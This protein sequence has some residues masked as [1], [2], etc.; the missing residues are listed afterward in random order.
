MLSDKIRIRVTPFI[1][2]VLQYDADRFYIYKNDES[3][4]MN[5]ML[6]ILIPNLLKLKISRRNDIC[7]ALRD[8]L[9][10]DYSNEIE[11]I[12]SEI[13]EKTLLKENYLGYL[14]N[15]IWIRPSKAVQTDFD[16][17]ENDELPLTKMDLSSYIRSLLNEY[18][19]LPENVRE[20]IFYS[21]EID[22][23]NKC[24]NGEYLIHFK[25]ENDKYLFYV[26][27]YFVGYFVDQAI[28]VVG[29]DVEKEQIRS[30]PLKEIYNLFASSKKY[31]AKREL[32]EKLKKYALK[33][34]F[35]KNNIIDF[36]NK[37]NA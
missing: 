28:Y 24:I 15:D 9:K 8:K 4:N 20:K 13:M 32:V 34:N 19:N 26:Y 22:I 10:M 2:H 12:A 18:V 11:S 36:K 3:P 7:D 35:K 31:N 16:K 30:F 29:F 1:F 14:D 33:Y 6:N 23:L 37:N 25:Y 21:H 27:N 17:I 5:L